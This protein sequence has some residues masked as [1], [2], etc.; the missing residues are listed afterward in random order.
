MQIIIFLLIIYI[1]IVSIIKMC[2]F[3]I[4]FKRWHLN[5]IYAFIPFYNT[6]LALKKY[7]FPSIY[8]ILSFFP[9]VRWYILYELHTKLA[10]LSSK[11]NSFAIGLTFLPCLYYPLLTKKEQKEENTYNMFLDVE[12]ALKEKGIPKEEII[13]IPLEWLPPAKSKTP[14]Y[15]AKDNEFIDKEKY[16]EPPSKKKEEKIPKIDYKICQKCHTRAKIDAKK[17]SVCGYKFVK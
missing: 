1:S 16:V 12:N 15:K 7:H 9:V 17:C 13:D 4:L 8:S 11:G 5:P 3:Y 6:I 2:S 14:S 10:R